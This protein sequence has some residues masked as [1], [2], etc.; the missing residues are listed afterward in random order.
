MGGPV[1]RELVVAHYM[2]Y[3]SLLLA[4][5]IR[6]RGATVSTLDGRAVSAVQE[7]RRSRDG[8]QVKTGKQP[9][10]FPFSED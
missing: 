10:P 2:G 9:A 7:R 6:S 1:V 5:E 4:N 3:V 8:A